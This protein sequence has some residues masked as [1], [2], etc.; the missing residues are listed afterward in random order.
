M[1]FVDYS[2]YTLVQL[3]HEIKHWGRQR[4]WAWESRNPR[5]YTAAVRQIC[6]LEKQRDKTKAV[7]TNI[8]KTGPKGHTMT[9]TDYTLRWKKVP[10]HSDSYLNNKELLLLTI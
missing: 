7:Y 5:D 4:D 8:T 9:A 3:D 10:T 1:A 6:T 2:E